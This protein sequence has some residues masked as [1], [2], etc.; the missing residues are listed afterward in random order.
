MI[1]K[2]YEPVPYLEIS[3][4]EGERVAAW[5][6]PE[7]LGQPDNLYMLGYGVYEGIFPYGNAT[8]MKPLRTKRE[9]IT[10]FVLDGVT[11]EGRIRLDSG[12]V[13]WT[14]DC[15]FCPESV[16]PRVL[17]HF[18]EEQVIQYDA[19]KWVEE[20]F[21]KTKNTAEFAELL[22]QVNIYGNINYQIS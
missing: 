8:G 9:K 21:R 20:R 14:G 22:E 6:P 10:S 13:V 16:F 19:R 4:A 5:I 18:S 17:T 15:A 11:P 3:L 1:E 12:T 7:L 2:L